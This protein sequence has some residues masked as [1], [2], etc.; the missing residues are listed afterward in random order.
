MLPEHFEEIKLG[1]SNFDHTIDPGL[2]DELRNN[3]VFGQHSAWEFCGYVYFLNGQFHE[4]VWRLKLFQETIS[5]DSLEELM[6][7]VNERWGGE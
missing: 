3:P 7:K 4:D 2:K 6:E 1:L 5:A